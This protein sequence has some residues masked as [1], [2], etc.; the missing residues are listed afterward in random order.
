MSLLGCVVRGWLLRGVCTVSLS[1]QLSKR[2][3][4]LQQD[5]T[6]L[7]RKNSRERDRA[8][9]VS[10]RNT[11]Q[12]VCLHACVS[13]CVE[14]Q[15]CTGIEDY[16]VLGACPTQPHPQSPLQDPAHA[17]A[18]EAQATELAKRV[19]ENDDLQR[20]VTGQCTLQ[21]WGGG[22]VLHSL[23]LPVLSV[24]LSVCLCM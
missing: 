13:T 23:V 16:T 6:P 4:S 8:A 19:T 7:N 10:Q 15:L 20:E 11:A 3:T 18:F 2:V 9:R 22:E 17:A 1:C 24:C 14:L 12:G 5:L 21:R